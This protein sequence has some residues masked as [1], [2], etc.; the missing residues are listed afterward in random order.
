M[1]PQKPASAIIEIERVSQVFQTSTRK[2]HVALSDISLTIDE[3]AFVSI[4]G[5]YRLW[6]VDLALRRRR[7]RQPDQRL[8]KDKGTDNHGARAGSRSGV[9]GIR[10]VSVE[11]RA[12]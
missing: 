9:S 4:L 1:R 12:G 3:G 5:P 11:D 7:L 8:S 2:D 10:V 6:Q